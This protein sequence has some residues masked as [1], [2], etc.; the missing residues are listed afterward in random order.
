M[1]GRPR[2]G[3]PIAEKGLRLDF[4]AH[5]I[6]RLDFDLANPL[7]GHAGFVGEDLPR[8]FLIFGEPA[9]LGY[10]WCDGKRMESQPQPRSHVEC[11]EKKGYGASVRRKHARDPPPG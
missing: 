6:H 11:D 2:W 7:R 3:E 1:S 9:V 10:L 5:L 8:F 4:L